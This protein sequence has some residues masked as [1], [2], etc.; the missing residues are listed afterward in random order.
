MLDGEDKSAKGSK[1]GIA[2][3]PRQA[4]ELLGE[5][6]ISRAS[7]YSALN[8]GDIP[9]RRL[10]RR[11]VIPRHAFLR[12]LEGESDESRPAA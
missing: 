11:I 2:L 8:R 5:G 3:S 1:L 4:L 12:W 7:F 6:V 10:G 9:S